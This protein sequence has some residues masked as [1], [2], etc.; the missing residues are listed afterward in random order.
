MKGILMYIPDYKRYPSGQLKYAFELGPEIHK[1]DTT[2][3]GQAPRTTDKM[4]STVV[5][6]LF[7]M[8]TGIY[9]TEG[10]C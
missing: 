7:N 6:H 10:E 3:W 8:Y 2:P 1:A 9:D 4:A 5:G